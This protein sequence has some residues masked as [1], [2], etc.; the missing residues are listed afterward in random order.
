MSAISAADA[1]KK[2]AL[3]DRTAYIPSAGVP[4]VGASAGGGWSCSGSARENEG[5]VSPAMGQA[6]APAN[7]SGSSSSVTPRTR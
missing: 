5:G 4:G 2:R 6:N 3:A 7:A 1:G